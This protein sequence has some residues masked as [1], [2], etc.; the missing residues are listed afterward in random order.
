MNMSYS[1]WLLDC[2]VIAYY[3]FVMIETRKNA[4]SIQFFVLVHIYNINVAVNM[5]HIRDP[6]RK[7]PSEIGNDNRRNSQSRLS[8]VLFGREREKLI[9]F[10][11]I[12]STAQN[13]T[14]ARGKATTVSLFRLLSFRHNIL[15]AIWCR[16]TVQARRGEN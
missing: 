14:N 7:T 11:H 13:G 9:A 10:H 3:L 8:R 4:S 16:E 12:N 6:W 2:L 5:R 1:K 15:V